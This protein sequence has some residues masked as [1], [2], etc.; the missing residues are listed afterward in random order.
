[1]ITQTT[2]TKTYTISPIEAGG[3]STY[4]V[5]IPVSTR[6]AAHLLDRVPPADRPFDAALPVIPTWEPSFTLPARSITRARRC[7][8]DDTE[9]LDMT[10]SNGGNFFD[11]ALLVGQKYTDSTYGVS[12]TVNSASATA[13][14]VTVAVAGGSPTTTTLKSSADPSPW[15]PP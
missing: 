15:V 4:A 10:P 13:L 1:M 12:V 11:S 6:P 2:G 9:I 8:G 3:Q 14:S 7:G 5:K